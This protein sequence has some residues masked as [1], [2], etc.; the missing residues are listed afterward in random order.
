MAELF[1]RQVVLR[2]TDAD[3][4]GRE[5]G[6]LRIDFNIKHTDA[7]EPSEGKIS[8]YNASPASVSLAQEEGAIVQLLL[9]YRGRPAKQ[10]FAGNV[11]EDGIEEVKQGPD[12]VLKLEC[13]DGGAEV[14]ST[15]G[16][17]FATKTSLAQVVDEL[18]GATGLAKGVIS[19]GV[20]VV[21]PYGVVLQG[22]AT[23][24]LTDLLEGAGRRWYIRDRAFQ[25]VGIGEGTGEPSPVFSVTAGN[26]IGSP[27]KT[28]DGVKVRALIGGEGQN[29]RPG[30]PFRIEDTARFD[31]DYLAETVIFRGSTWTN[32]YYL[33]AEGVAL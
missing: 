20:G 14:R 22:V 3:G 7:E 15:I 8:I 17:T 31:G 30:K 5:F 12:R 19:L 29:L 21:F 13:A 27:S 2:V 28:K 9:G 16:R 25:I 1:G 32:D 26:L 23:R 6:D 18:I 24:V 4:V 33:E 10:V 11:I